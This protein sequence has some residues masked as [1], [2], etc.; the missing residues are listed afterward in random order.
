MESLH[1]LDHVSKTA[2]EDWTTEEAL[3]G[4]GEEDQMA[5]LSA[6]R[7][8]WAPRSKS[9][10]M[11]STNRMKRT[12][13]STEPW[14]TPRLMRKERL[15]EPPTWTLALRSERK[16]AHPKNEARREFERE[17]FVK[18]SR[19]PDR[20]E[21][22]GGSQQKPK[23]FGL[24]VLFFFGSRPRLIETEFGQGV[25]YQDESRPGKVERR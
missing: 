21:S 7:E 9:L 19:V 20:V 2:M 25:T 13:P 6:Y 22:L 18:K 5:R 8:A 23:S 4:S 17:E 1:K 16:V 15:W 10:V 12:R 24:E 11:S 3:S 14:G